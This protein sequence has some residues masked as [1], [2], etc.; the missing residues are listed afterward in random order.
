MMK[1]GV[2][3][4]L[5]GKPLLEGISMASKIGAQGIQIYGG[6]GGH[7]YNFTDLKDDEIK[8][9]RDAC[10]E[11]NLEITAV[12]G[13]ISPKSFQVESECQ[14]R[15]DVAKK[16]LD[17]MVKLGD[18]KIMT[19]HIGCIPDSPADPVYD[20]MVSSVRKAAEHAQSVGCKFAIETGPELAD[21]LKR[22][23]AD[24]G[25]P[26]L[27]INLGPANLRGVSC[28]DPVYAVETLYPYIVHTHAKDAINKYVG[29]AAK[30]YGLRNPDGS[31]REISSRP[32]GFQEVPLGEG[33]VPWDAYLQ[34]LKNHGYDGFLTIERECG[35]NPAR[36]IKIAV[37]FLQYQLSKLA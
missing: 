31:Y 7:G 30:F 5:L 21:V 37:S 33:M 9:I 10:A 32:S 17:N 8:Q 19:T 25:C 11:N 36:D 20:T 15:V 18:V 1:I 28:E 2:I 29:S 6:H 34:A 26:A 24:V 27:G 12:C 3:V 35:E 16:V 14:E 4:E 22:F 23:I 13:D